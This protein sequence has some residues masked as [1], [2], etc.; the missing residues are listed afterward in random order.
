MKISL[1]NAD[2]TTIVVPDNYPTIGDAIQNAS[3]GDI[4]LVKTGTYQ[5]NPE[6]TKP[7]IVRG[8]DAAT[9]VII[10]SGGASNSSVF[11]VSADNVQ[12]SGFTI[13]SQNYSKSAQ[14]ASGILVGGDNCTI[15]GNIITNVNK[16][17]YVGGWGDLCGAKC[18]TTITENNITGSFGDGIRMFGGYGNNISK[19]I[20]V[21]SNTSAISVAGYSNYITGNTLINNRRGLGLGSANSVIHANSI[22]GSLDWAIYF[23]VSNDIISAN[24]IE[25]NRIGVYL[26]P[27]FAPGS[28]QFFHNNF[29]NNTVQVKTGSEFNVQVWD[30]RAPGGGNY[31]SN[32]TGTDA[33]NDGTGDTAFELDA[34]NID[35][36]PLTAAFNVSKAGN[37]P[38]APTSGAVQA[39]H[40]AALWHFD[41]VE[42]NG[43]TPDATG[44]NPV[45]IGDA[46][47]NITCPPEPV[48][49]QG[50]Y[51]QALLFDIPQYIYGT[52]SASLDITEEIT[53]DAWINLTYL[54]NCTYNNIIVYGART[55]DKYQSRVWGFA[56]SGQD[57][58]NATS[59]PPGALQGYV[60][61]D[62]G[63]N[64]IVTTESVIP[65]NI[66]THVTFTRSQT[67]GMHL[68]VNGEEKSVKAVYG[69]Q[70][71]S[72]NI[73]KG[74]E[75]NIGHDIIGVIDELRV[76][77]IAIEPQTETPASTQ[78]PTAT[79]SAAPAETTNSVLWLQWWF[80][81]L[82]AGGFVVLGSAFFLFRKSIFKSLPK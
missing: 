75:L 45:V 60:Y 19:N 6:I 50:K 70:N 9:T 38:P 69:V 46:K 39:D 58:E 4:I 57:P 67:T 59:G 51:G 1:A 12:I 14:Y 21:G 27:T 66:W 81:T 68:Y 64:E 29:I 54:Q 7:L 18:F 52:A 26:S 13:M 44:N 72:G 28:N 8:E 80:W 37:P 22:T 71:P 76:S 31:W 17:I 11:L 79:P 33:D 41:T 82:L 74:T 47:G 35:N 2:S 78:Q 56:V 40:T 15:T 16:G 62:S 48:Y 55:L 65:V 42:S 25:N 20:V 49:V 63:Y 61:T 32:Y 73:K 24:A 3:P 34:N 30:N 77:N 5:E 53:L 23:Q 10:G 36:Y 43:V